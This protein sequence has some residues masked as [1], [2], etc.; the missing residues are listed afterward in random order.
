MKE[1][2]LA[3]LK[4]WT[5]KHGHE[6]VIMQTQW[7]P[8]LAAMI[9]S[10]NY[11]CGYVRVPNEHSLF[12]IDSFSISGIDAH[13][14]L[15]YA[16]K[17]PGDTEDSYEWWIGFDCAHFGDTEESCTTEYCVDQCERMSKQLSEI[18]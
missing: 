8:E 7:E 15:T 5:T 4:K 13:G 10:G 1:I 18:K 6:A 12:L 16:G 9:P 2:T 14:G 3:V 11:R 17:K